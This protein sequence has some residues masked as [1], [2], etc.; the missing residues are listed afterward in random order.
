MKRSISLILAFALLLAL[1]PNT[2]QVRSS[3]VEAKTAARD[4]TVF[5]DGVYTLALAA[6]GSAS[7]YEDGSVRRVLDM[8]MP[9]SS[10]SLLEL[11]ATP[12]KAHSSLSSGSTAKTRNTI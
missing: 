7:D 10:Q 3:A 9:D 12:A 8:A 5:V 4:A 1:L 6:E 2:W 11:N